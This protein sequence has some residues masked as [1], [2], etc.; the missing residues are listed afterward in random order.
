MTPH[1]DKVIL[2]P[3]SHLI[4]KNTCRLLD[5]SPCVRFSKQVWAV[6]DYIK[7]SPRPG[8]KSTQAICGSFRER[9]QCFSEGNT[10]VAWI[11]AWWSCLL[12]TAGVRLPFSAS[13]YRYVPAHLISLS[14]KTCRG[15]FIDEHAE[16]P[17][18]Y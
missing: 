12:F 3:G 16:A 15:G 9:M 17:G 7:H 14:H 5:A 11:K 8:E 1:P 4:W 6:V 18:D 10:E 13:E 2:A